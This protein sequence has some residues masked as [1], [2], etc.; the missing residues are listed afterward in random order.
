LQSQQ[1]LKFF[2]SSQLEIRLALVFGGQAVMAH[3]VL[4]LVAVSAVSV[5]ADL[6]EPLEAVL[7]FQASSECLPF[8]ESVEKNC[9]IYQ[10]AKDRK[11]GIPVNQSQDLHAMEQ[12]CDSTSVCS[13]D[14][15]EATQHCPS[16]REAI[17]ITH[18]VCNLVNSEKQVKAAC[19]MTHA[20]FQACKAVVE[21]ETASDACDLCSEPCKQSV[22][23]FLL[24]DHPAKDYPGALYQEATEIDKKTTEALSIL[25]C[26]CGDAPLFP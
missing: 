8:A 11:L 6:P 10:L 14:M 25:G 21:S 22:C 15:E 2:C 1:W 18:S 20:K 7:T 24:F 26:P 16:I 17:E 9:Y 23:N 3:F 12:M 19:N 5:L 4:V 13:S